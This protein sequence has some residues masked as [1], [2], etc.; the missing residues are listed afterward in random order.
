MIA[1]K[2]QS[3]YTPELFFMIVIDFLVWHANFEITLAYLAIHN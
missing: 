2:K 3:K 1:L